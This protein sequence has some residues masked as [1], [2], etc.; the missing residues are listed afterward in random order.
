MQ[1]AHCVYTFRPGT[2]DALSEPPHNLRPVIY[3][4]IFLTL[5][6]ACMLTVRKAT[7]EDAQ[8]VAELLK[9]KYSFATVDEAR[10][11]FAYESRYHHFRVAVDGNNCL[12]LISWR[13]QGMLKHGVA[14][15]TRLAVLRSAPDPA[16]IKEQLFDAAMAEAELHYRDHGTRLRKIFSMIHADN[17]HLQKF[18]ETKG[19]HTEAVLK[20]HF[21]FGQD[22]LVL[23]MFFA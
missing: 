3:R 15:V 5:T 2:L 23:S 10:D 7:A 16:Q 19:M 12:G 6:H 8:R 21:R 4:Y 1:A 17:T 13:P 22:E 18:L 14:E 20:D 9:A 11:T